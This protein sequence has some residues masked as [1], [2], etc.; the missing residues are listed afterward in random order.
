M[1]EHRH[2]ISIKLGAVALNDLTLVGGISL[3]L[4]G[5]NTESLLT[6]GFAIKVLEKGVRHNRG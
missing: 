6:V 3:S 5:F 1:L 2:V 4:Q